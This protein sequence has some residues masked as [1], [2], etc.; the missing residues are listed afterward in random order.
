[1][2]LPDARLD[3]ARTGVQAMRGVNER[4]GELSRSPSWL[5]IICILRRR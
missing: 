1:M 4:T 2:P 5:V 3:A